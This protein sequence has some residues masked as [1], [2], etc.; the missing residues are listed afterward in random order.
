[1]Y[2]H[3]F[4]IESNR[5]RKRRTSE[6]LMDDEETMT[7]CSA[8]MLLMKLSCSPHSNPAMSNWTLS[9]GTIG[10]NG[11]LPSYPNMPSPVDSSG[12]LMTLCFQRMIDSWGFQKFKIW[13]LQWYLKQ[14]LEIIFILLTLFSMNFCMLKLDET[15]TLLIL[16]FK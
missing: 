16:K 11:S 9:Q 15:S 4:C 1:M 12:K 10:H 2:N 3:N 7:E 5:S 6:T 13:N 8:A 14:K